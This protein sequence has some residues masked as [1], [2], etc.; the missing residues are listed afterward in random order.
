MDGKGQFLVV[1]K[2]KGKEIDEGSRY[3]GQMMEFEVGSFSRLKRRGL[4][5]YIRAIGIVG[6]DN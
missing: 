3:K 6:E 5:I 1:M 2:E 4:N